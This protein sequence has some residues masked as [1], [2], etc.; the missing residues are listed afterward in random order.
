MC[1]YV[2]MYLIDTLIMPYDKILINVDTVYVM[3]SVL[4]FL[5]IV[6][7]IITSTYIYKLLFSKLPAFKLMRCTDLDLNMS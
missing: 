2:S 4:S 3:L 1:M 6:I 5:L 7:L